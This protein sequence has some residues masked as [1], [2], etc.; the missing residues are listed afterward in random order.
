MDE[1]FAL[2]LWARR[3]VGILVALL[4]VVYMVVLTAENGVVNP[5][6][7]QNFRQLSKV[8]RVYAA[9]TQDPEKIFQSAIKE[10][11]R[12]SMF[13]RFYWEGL[14]ERMDMM[15]NRHR[16]LAEQHEKVPEGY[17]YDLQAYQSDDVQL[18]LAGLVVHLPDT[19]EKTALFRNPDRFEILKG[20][21]SP[22]RD[23]IR[24]YL[25]RLHEFKWAVVAARFNPGA[26]IGEI[27]A[28][29]EDWSL[30]IAVRDRQVFPS[31]GAVV[32]WRLGKQA[33]LGANLPPEDEE[34]EP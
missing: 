11:R 22:A 18:P 23:L 29:K 13:E 14:Q 26:G 24:E 16:A 19:D 33:E 8:K 5:K 12:E 1:G 30:S 34:S 28:S 21:R 7:P 9:D 3:G 27:H 10:R 15:I 20:S 25:Q 6:R 17:T 32:C 2:G 4:V 31:Y